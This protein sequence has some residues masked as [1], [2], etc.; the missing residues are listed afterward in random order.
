MK[1]KTLY[2][3][4]AM[5]TIALGSVKTY[6]GLTQ[7]NMSVLMMENMEALTSGEDGHFWLDLFGCNGGNDKC[8]T[9]TL[10]FDGF[11]ISGTW[12]KNPT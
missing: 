4:V 3:I 12:Y 11:E 10:S 6:N 7:N 2:G 1:K 8:F 9:G 5:M